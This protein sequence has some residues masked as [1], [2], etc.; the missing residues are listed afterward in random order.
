MGAFFLQDLMIY[1][2]QSMQTEKKVAHFGEKRAAQFRGA[3]P[4]RCDVILQKEKRITIHGRISN[5]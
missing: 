2:H 3:I 1:M 5:T 4:S